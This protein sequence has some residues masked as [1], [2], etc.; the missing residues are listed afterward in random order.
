MKSLSL[1]SVLAAAVRGVARVG[2]GNKVQT[3]NKVKI[4]TK[5]NCKGGVRSV[6]Q[7]GLPEDFFARVL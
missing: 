4:Q 2:W 6:L 7:Q 5:P 1:S 3:L